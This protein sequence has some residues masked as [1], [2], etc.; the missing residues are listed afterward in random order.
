MQQQTTQAGRFGVTSNVPPGITKIL[1]SDAEAVQI[2][3]LCSRTLFTLRQ[4][5]KLR[6]RR[7]GSRVLY[8][9]SDLEALAEKLLVK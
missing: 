4:Q 6:Y 5:R 7:A 8:H 2:T 1:F 3:G 9:I